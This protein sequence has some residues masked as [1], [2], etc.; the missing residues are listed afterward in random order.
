MKAATRKLQYDERQLRALIRFEHS[1]IT[2]GTVQ[3]PYEGPKSELSGRILLNLLALPREIWKWMKNKLALSLALSR[4]MAN[5]PGHDTAQLPQDIAQIYRQIGDAQATYNLEAVRNLVGQELFQKLKARAQ[6]CRLGGWDHIQWS[7]EN[8]EHLSKNIKLVHGRA[9]KSEENSQFEWIQLT[10][11]I[12]SKQRFAAYKLI[13]EGRVV[14]DQELVAG[15]PDQLIDVED[16]WVF[17][18][19]TKVPIDKQ[20]IPLENSRWRLVLQHEF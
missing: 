10:F 18:R 1:A 20:Q 9:L 19:K 5:I 14:K 3:Q 7:I 4:C 12:R 17:E 13:K 11:R 15:D 16:Y 2:L 8:D 6:T